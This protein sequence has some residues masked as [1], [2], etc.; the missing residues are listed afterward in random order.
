MPHPTTGEMTTALHDTLQFPGTFQ[1][2]PGGFMTTAPPTLAEQFATSTLQ[3]LAPQDY[4]QQSNPNLS[5]KTVNNLRTELKS[6]LP[7]HNK[8]SLRDIVNQT[9]KQT[10]RDLF[11]GK[12]VGGIKRNKHTRIK[13]RK[14]RIKR[15]KPQ[16]KRRK[17]IKSLRVGGGIKRHRNPRRKK[18]RSNRSRPKQRR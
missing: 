5:P 1:E 3:P 7:F 17:S 2:D 14:P 10:R 13:R 16:I 12:R 9:R 4:H 8:R 15:R 11:K 6:K 18:S